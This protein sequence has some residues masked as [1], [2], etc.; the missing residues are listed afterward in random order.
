MCSTLILAGLLA[1]IIL[2]EDAPDREFPAAAMGI[3][4]GFTIATKMTAL[5]LLITI[6]LLQNW[7]SRLVVVLS[8][9]VTAI[10]CTLPI[11]IH[12]PDLIEWF[13][14]LI[15]R[16]EIYGTGKIGFISPAGVWHNVLLCFADAPEIFVYLLVYGFGASVLAVVRPSSTMVLSRLLW[17]VTMVFAVQLLMV[18]R[19]PQAHSHY[20]VP[21]IAMACLANAALAN[22]LIARCAPRILGCGVVVTA[23][24]VG[25]VNGA[26][27]TELWLEASYAMRRENEVLLAKVSADGCVLIPY[28]TVDI[29]EYELMFGNEYAGSH[30]GKQLSR[31]Y[32]DYL[33]YQAFG[34]YFKNFSGPVSGS[35]LVERLS[36]EK[37][38]YL[39]EWP[40]ERFEQDTSG[41]FRI[42][43][44]FLRL[45]GQTDSVGVYELLP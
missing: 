15:T 5:S 37:C 44:N 31:L 36:R 12:Y 40:I 33:G 23:C 42:P 22:F 2:D 7:R 14:R 41:S 4:L 24:V 45:V 8:T 9:A 32:P 43:R 19:Q 13:V 16:N 3:V 38:N 34:N 30:F 28:Y 18:L 25:F 6:F 39:I 29:R 26:R 21:V 35:E 17:V 20:L 11:A 27:A 1:P 10:I